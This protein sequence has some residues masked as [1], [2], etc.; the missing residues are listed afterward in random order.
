MAPVDFYLFLT[1]TYWLA[2][3]TG[4]LTFA[5]ILV[6]ILQ[7]AFKNRDRFVLG[8]FSA[9]FIM[10][11]YNLFSEISDRMGKTEAN[12]TLY[13]LVILSFV[14]A[15]CVGI[16]A[17]Q[18]EGSLQAKWRSSGLQWLGAASL[19]L[20]FFYPFFCKSTTLIILSG[21]VSILPHPTLAVLL[22]VLL[23]TYP[24][25]P[26]LPMLAAGVG[27]L[28]LGILDF[29]LGLQSSLLLA[30]LGTLLLVLQ[31]TGA[32]RSG[33]VLED[34]RPP[35]DVEARQKSKIFIQ[36]KADKERTWKLK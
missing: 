15:L 28:A 27:A 17:A 22:G 33:G 18:P 12:T 13:V 8:L 26:R 23:L 10:I 34:D 25:G 2:G 36:K 29:W 9:Q 11:A 4:K 16:G 35:V 19:L 21:S 14:M 3:L 6:L 7:P 24:N 1:S 31:I 5:L 30:G 20:G 32:I